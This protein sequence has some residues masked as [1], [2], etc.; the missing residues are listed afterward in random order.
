ME[1]DWYGKE[2]TLDE[3]VIFIN[4][5]EDVKLYRECCEHVCKLLKEILKATA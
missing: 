3:N 4:E 2:I 5:D 1:Y